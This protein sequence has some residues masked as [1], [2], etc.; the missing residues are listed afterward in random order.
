MGYSYSGSAT[1]SRVIGIG[2]LGLQFLLSTIAAGGHCLGTV[3][4]RICSINYDV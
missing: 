2:L 4:H 3:E 1:P